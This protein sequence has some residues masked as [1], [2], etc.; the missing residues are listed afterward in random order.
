MEQALESYPD[1]ADL[2][3]WH[4]GLILDEL[5]W[6]FNPRL[7]PLPRA[8]ETVNRAIALDRNNA[9]AHH[10][11]ALAQHARRDFEAFLAAAERAVALNPNQATTLVT[12]GAFMIVSGKLERGMALANKGI[13]LN[14]GGAGWYHFAPQHYHY[15][16]GEYEQ[17]LAAALKINMPGFFLNHAVLA[18]DYAQLGRMEEAQAEV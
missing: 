6:G 5:R 15:A 17:A 1:D 8:L 12:M 10:V 2:L 13:A 11:L 9:L 14:P 16:R 7:D 18:A 4:A 3:A